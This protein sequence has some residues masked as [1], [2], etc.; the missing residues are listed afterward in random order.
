MKGLS[1]TKV[2]YANYRGKTLTSYFNC[3]GA[4]MY[5]LGHEKRLTWIDQGTMIEWLDENTK[6]HCSPSCRCHLR[7]E[8]EFYTLPDNIQPGDILTMWKGDDLVHTAVYI[9]R[10]KFFH[11]RGE[12]TSEITEISWILWIYGGCT[13]LV[14]RRLI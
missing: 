12:S 14:Y 5:V 8:E 4:T 2:Y 11:K 7:S 6:H 1:R 3:W 10:G 9:G 13:H